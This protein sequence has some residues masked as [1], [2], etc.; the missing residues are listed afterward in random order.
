MRSKLAMPSSPHATASPSMMQ[1]RGRN[2][3]SAST[4]S[5]RP[6]VE[7]REVARERRALVLDIKEGGSSERS[8]W[9]IFK[10]M[11]RADCSMS[12]LAELTELVGFF[13]YSREDDEAFRG[14]LSALREGIQR[15]LS[16]QL[17]RSKRNFRL[18]Q[19]QAAIA[20]LGP[21]CVCYF[22]LFRGPPFQCAHPSLEK[23]RSLNSRKNSESSE[24]VAVALVA[25]LLCE[26]SDLPGKIA[27]D[28]PNLRISARPL[29]RAPV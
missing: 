4:I 12:T 25:P 22:L 6:A 27:T 2:W 10:S 13:S 23:S 5:G 28:G 8:F 15:E 16:A 24:E 1:D 19:D 21:L 14:T 7:P 29:K 17:G 3:A 20:G 18:W 9:V 11:P 26:F